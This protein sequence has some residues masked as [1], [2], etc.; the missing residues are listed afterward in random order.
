MSRVHIVCISCV[1]YYGPHI[2]VSYVEIKVQ[3]LEGLADTSALNRTS[4]SPRVRTRIHHFTGRLRRTHRG[5]NIFKNDLLT[6]LRSVENRVSQVNNNHSLVSQ[7]TDPVHSQK[8]QSTF[9]EVTTQ[10][11][12][13]ESVCMGLSE[14]RHGSL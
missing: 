12:V 9:G 6:L 7:D 13:M 11:T 4:A 14:L 8:A 3:E 2:H 5:H 10:G 1:L